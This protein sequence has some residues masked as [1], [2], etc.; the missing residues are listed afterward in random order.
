ML[1]PLRF[2]HRLHHET[3]VGGIRRA[4]RTLESDRQSDEPLALGNRRALLHVT[5]RVT[6]VAA[7]DGDQVAATLDAFSLLRAAGRGDSSGNEQGASRDRTKSIS[8]FHDPVLHQKFVW[9]G[10][11]D[12]GAEEL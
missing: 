5:R 9:S 2:S 12:I 6:V 1:Q 11:V 4:P 3:Q 7:A 8:S 10:I